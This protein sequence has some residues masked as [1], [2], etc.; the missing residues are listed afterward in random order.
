MKQIKHASLTLLFMGILG[1]STSVFAQFAI[2]LDNIE[3]RPISAKLHGEVEGEPNFYKGWTKATVHL[4]NGEKLGNVQVKYDL[5]DDLLIFTDKSGELFYFRHP[6]KEFWL[7]A[8]GAADVHFRSGYPEVD[9]RLVTNFYQVLVDGKISLVKSYRK[10]LQ[11]AQVYGSTTKKFFLNHA[12][13]LY[14]FA[15]HRMIKVRKNEKAVLDAVGNDADKAALK[16]IIA[17][18]KLNLRKE[19]DLIALFRSFNAQ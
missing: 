10:N 12:E 17:Q 16:Q 9:G 15:N 3:G 6:V 4:A 11:E 5:V 18:Q 13:N 19:E 14:L 7:H 2:V 1:A 8:E